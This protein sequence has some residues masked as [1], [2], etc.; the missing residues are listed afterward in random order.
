MIFTALQRTGYAPGQALL[1]GD[2][3]YTDVASALNAGIDAAFVLSGEGTLDDVEKT[4]IRPTFV[5]Q[6]VGELTRAMSEK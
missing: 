5:F 3:L 4:G 6:D 1:V 2:R